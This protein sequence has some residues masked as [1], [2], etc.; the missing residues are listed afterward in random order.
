[1]RRGRPD[2]YGLIR[3]VCERNG[4]LYRRYH[5][6]I[7]RFHPVDWDMI[8]EMDSRGH[9][10][11]SHTWS[12]RNLSLLPP[13]ERALE[14]G[15]SKEL[16]EDQLGKPVDVI[17][18]PYGDPSA[19]DSDCMRLAQECGYKKGLM[20]VN[21]EVPGP[22]GMNLSRFSLPRSRFTPHL[23]AAVSGFKFALRRPRRISS[24]GGFNKIDARS[25]EYSLKPRL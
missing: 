5:E 4:L 6:D 24:S 22:P 11:A 9:V 17:V 16:L 15:K 20:N 2:I 21:F 23:Y 7:L 1:V 12:H 18:Y 14:L 10:I 19:V 8:R 13:E 3:E 25:T